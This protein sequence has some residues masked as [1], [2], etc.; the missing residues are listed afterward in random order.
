VYLRQEHVRLAVGV[1]LNLGSAC[2]R[3]AIGVWEESEQIVEAVVLEI[4]DDDVLNVA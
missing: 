1:N 3:D 2:G 4:D